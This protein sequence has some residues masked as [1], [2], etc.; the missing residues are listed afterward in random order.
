MVPRKADATHQVSTKTAR[1]Q[2]RHDKGKRRQDK[3][4]QPRQEETRQEEIRHEAASNGKREGGQEETRQEHTGQEGT[5]QL[6]DKRSFETTKAAATS[7]VA[8]LLLVHLMHGSTLYNKSS[9]YKNCRILY[10]SAAALKRDP[11]ILPEE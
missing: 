5:G 1:R 6:T 9:T 4:K 7:P 8:N 11:E 3:M 2:M 10:Y